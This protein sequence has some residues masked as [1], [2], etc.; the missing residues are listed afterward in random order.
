[1]ST[2]KWVPL[3]DRVLLRFDTVKA[4]SDG[5]I[6]LEMTKQERPLI[7]TILACGDVAQAAGWRAGK[8]VYA[9][10]FGGVDVVLDCYHSEG[11]EETLRVVKT[12]ELL[13]QE[14][15]G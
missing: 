11:R 12:A 14:V 6:I 8:R 9:S 7:A 10:K 3:G 4:V 13:L 5:G 1:M 2:A 15:V